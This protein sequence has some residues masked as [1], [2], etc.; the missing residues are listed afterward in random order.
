MTSIITSDTHFGCKYFEAKTFSSFL[1][2][3]PADAELILAG[4]VVDVAY[5]G[6]TGTHSNA[7]ERLIALSERQ[8]VV[9]VRGNHDRKFSPAD[10]GQ[11][12]MVDEYA[13]GK[14]L[15][16]AH[17][18]RFDNIMPYHQWF[19]HL[20]HAIHALRIL[21]GAGT[22]HVAR[23]AKRFPTLYAVLCNHVARNAI[24][25]AKEQGFQAV[26]CGHTHHAE[27]REMDGI[28]YFNTG[29]WTEATPH[30]LVATGDEMT[31][32]PVTPATH[33][34]GGPARP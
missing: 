33:D 31:L 3:L 1:D 16:I 4:D 9:W 8:P 12:R 32:H 2:T 29:A 28:R 20:F 27:E 10:S 11:I 30:Y 22:I 6:F 5:K 19:I 7:L 21:L 18:H 34:D 14:R 26:V 24:Q 25:H 17:G 23:H 15:Y 13:I